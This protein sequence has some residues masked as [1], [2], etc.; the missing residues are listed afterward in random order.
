M[1]TIKALFTAVAS[2]TGGRNGHAEAEDHSVSVNLSVPKAM[3][4]PGKPGTTT[5][6]TCLLLAMRRALAA[7]LIT[8][9]LRRKKAPRTQRLP[10]AYRSDR[11]TRAGSGWPSSCMLRIRACLR[12]NYQHW[13]A[14]R[15][16]R[17]A[18]TLTPRE[19]TFR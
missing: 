12:R 11:A 5:L 17:S 19:E 18:L 10:V 4:G 2:V 3:G 9:R 15:M 8:L 13:R 16:R 14:R 7:P 6:S 1:D